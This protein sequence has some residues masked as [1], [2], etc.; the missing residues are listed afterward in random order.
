MERSGIQDCPAGALPDC[1]AFHPGYRIGAKSSLSIFVLDGVLEQI[2]IAFTLVPNSR[3]SPYPSPCQG[4]GA[5]L[6]HHPFAILGKAQ[7]MSRRA[8]AAW[9]LAAR[10]LASGGSQEQALN[11]GQSG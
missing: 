9:N 7:P 1:T 6:S 4:N 5:Q 3:P 11:R 8:F 10:T 2:A